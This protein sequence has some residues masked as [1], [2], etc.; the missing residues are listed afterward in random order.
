MGNRYR[1]ATG[2]ATFFIPSDA[3]AVTLPLRAQFPGAGGA[4]V[5]VRVSLDDRFLA[6]ILL[7][8]PDAWVKTILPLPSRPT[9][10]RHRRIDLRVNRTVGPSNFG[11]QVGDIT[12]AQ[13]DQAR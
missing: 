11:V 1:I 6:E 13:L 5:A 9:R 3:T 8:D 2:H 4:P 7:R 12:L 10:R